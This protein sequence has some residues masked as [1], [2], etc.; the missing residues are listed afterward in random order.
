VA[1]PYVEK[2]SVAVVRIMKKYNLPCAMKPLKALR[3]MLVHPKDKEETEQI[4]ECI[5]KVPRASCDKT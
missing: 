5:Y 3:S 1:I 4:I 2:T